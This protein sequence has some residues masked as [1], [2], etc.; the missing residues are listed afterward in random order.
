VSLQQPYEGGGEGQQVNLGLGA[1]DSASE[2][3][4][5]P[6]RGG[7]HPAIGQLT[8]GAA[9]AANRSACAMCWSAM[10]KPALPQLLLRVEP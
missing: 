7:V 5:M 2:P 9:E 3:G 8:D 6:A 4:S 1:G 10:K